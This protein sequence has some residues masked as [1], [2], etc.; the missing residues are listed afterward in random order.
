MLEDPWKISN[1]QPERVQLSRGE[2][3]IFIDETARRLAL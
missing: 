3:P 2:R 1:V